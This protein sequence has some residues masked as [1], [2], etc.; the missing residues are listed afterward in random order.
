MFYFSTTTKEYTFLPQTH[1]KC[2]R[3]IFVDGDF[4]KVFDEHVISGNFIYKAGH[5]IKSV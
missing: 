1:T 3:N 5:A 2:F 4:V